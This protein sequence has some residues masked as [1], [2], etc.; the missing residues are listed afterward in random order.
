MPT[1]SLILTKQAKKAFAK[2][3]KPYRRAVTHSLE[4]LTANSLPHQAAKL[5]GRTNH[6]RVRVGDYRIIYRVDHGILTILVIKI[7]HRQD[8]YNK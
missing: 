1:Y 4:A 2:L 6:Y 3:S 7:G 8:V 5:R